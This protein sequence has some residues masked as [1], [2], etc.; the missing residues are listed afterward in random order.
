[1]SWPDYRKHLLSASYHLAIAPFRPTPL[2]ECRSHN[3]IHDHAALGAAGLYGDIGPYRTS[4]THKH[5]GL[6]L[7]SHPSAWLA[8]LSALIDDPERTRR[9][10]ENGSALSRK[11]GDPARLRAFWEKRL[12]ID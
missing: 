9:L 1:L 8:N 12:G 5:D 7:P 11:I 6:V 4:V 2:N 10:A 3:K